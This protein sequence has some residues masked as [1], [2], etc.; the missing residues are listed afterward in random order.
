MGAIHSVQELGKTIAANRKRAGMTQ[1][2]L[3]TV[4]GVGDRF[5]V[6]LEAGKETVRF[7]L[8]LQVLKVLGI[9]LSDD[10]ESP[11]LSHDARADGMAI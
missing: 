11:G 3:A 8:V 1:R 4:A 9:T 10:P 6:D 2:D 5:I 7:G